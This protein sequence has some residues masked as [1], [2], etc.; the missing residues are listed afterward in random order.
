MLHRLQH[1]PTICAQI[2]GRGGDRDAM[3][4]ILQL[5]FCARSNAVGETRLSCALPLPLMPGR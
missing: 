5:A 3:H 1:T 4:I 2:M